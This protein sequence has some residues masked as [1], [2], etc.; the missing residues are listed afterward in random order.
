MANSRSGYRLRLVFTSDF[1]CSLIP[2]FLVGMVFA[3][4]EPSFALGTEEVGGPSTSFRQ[5]SSKDG[6]RT[7]KIPNLMANGCGSR[8][9]SFQF[10]S[11]ET[12]RCMV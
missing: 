9:G 11:F 12:I 5:M 8:H 6:N 2:F 1:F 4:F 3:P 7:R 10:S